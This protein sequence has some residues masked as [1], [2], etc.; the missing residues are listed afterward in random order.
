MVAEP[1]GWTFWVRGAPAVFFFYIL[2]SAV[3]GVTEAM[4]EQAVV[5]ILQRQAQL[6][7]AFLEERRLRTEA[8]QRLS[9]ELAQQAN[10]AV[11]TQPV[12]TMIDT[13]LL[14]KPEKFD[15]TDVHWR[16]W[17]FVTKSYLQAA[18]PGIGTL[19][20]KAEATTDDISNEFLSTAMLQMS[21]QL[22]YVLVLLTKFRALDKS[23]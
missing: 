5:D 6:E 22:Y 19:L 9:T 8:E 20:T 18:M 15:G 11:P 16:D 10:G 2:L 17:K 7:A 3:T 23:R 1:R 13:R 14:G 12:N 4:S 21:T